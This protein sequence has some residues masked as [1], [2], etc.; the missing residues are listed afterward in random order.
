MADTP[1]GPEELQNF[2]HPMLD[3]LALDVG[4]DVFRVIEAGWTR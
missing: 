4:D 2:D 1:F 3:W